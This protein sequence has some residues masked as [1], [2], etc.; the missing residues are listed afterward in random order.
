MDLIDR[1]AAR[2]GYVKATA[3]KLPLVESSPLPLAE[4]AA[5]D[6]APVPADFGLPPDV[7][8]IVTR[9]GQQGSHPCTWVEAMD[10]LGACG[11]PLLTLSGEV[12]LAT[13]FAGVPF[14]I[15]GADM[16]F[17]PLLTE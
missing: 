5:E 6:S 14:H 13:I 10:F 11:I 16:T 2:F 9:G 3:C 12:T 4:H 17:R 1:I 15:D 7:T 8:F